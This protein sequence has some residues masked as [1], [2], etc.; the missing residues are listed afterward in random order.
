MNKKIL[1]IF[2][3]TVLSA[4]VFLPNAMPE[5]TNEKSEYSETMST[6][7]T[8][9]II[10]DNA[11][12]NGKEG[13]FNYN[14]EEIQY[15][16]ETCEYSETMSTEPTVEIIGDSAQNNGK[17]GTFNYN[18]EEIQY[19]NGKPVIRLFSTSSCPHC[20]WIKETFDR[21]VKEY[22]QNDQIV[23]YHWNLNT[24]DNTLTTEVET[25]VSSF[26]LAV[27][28]TYNP[29]GSVPTFVFGNKYWRIGN[30]YEREN[31]LISEESEFR[32][33]IENLIKITK[34]PFESDET[35]V[36]MST[37]DFKLDYKSI[38]FND[39]MHIFN[40]NLEITDYSHISNEKNYNNYVPPC[41]TPPFGLVGWWPFDERQGPTAEELRR[42]LDGTHINNPNPVVG[43]VDW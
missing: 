5:H 8:V 20:E 30:G 43:K 3:V 19:E 16:N 42:K 9:E 27:F 29:G 26:E 24:G 34:Y 7:P 2:V 17:E 28:R 25:E 18:Q 4:F 37:F 38:Y 35:S 32:N 21:V 39:L 11:Q 10:G 1:G 40:S 31:D 41:L 36:E 12:N 23:A 33:I 22:V 6:E 14:Q 13:T 15:K